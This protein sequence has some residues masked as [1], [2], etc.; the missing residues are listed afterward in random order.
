MSVGLLL[1]SYQLKFEMH[2]FS[3]PLALRKDLYST[4]YNI[5]IHPDKSSFGPSGFLYHWL[6]KSLPARIHSIYL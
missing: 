4:F 5:L 6:Q 2:S 3:N 1:E